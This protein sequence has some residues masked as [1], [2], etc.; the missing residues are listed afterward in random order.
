MRRSYLLGFLGCSLIFAVFTAAQSTVSGTAVSPNANEI[1][2]LKGR[3]D[4]LEL[5]LDPYPPKFKDDREK[6]QVE[7]D[8][9]STIRDLQNASAAAPQNVT[10][11]CMLGHTY[12]L[13]QNLDQVGDWEKSW[14]CY[15]RAIELVPKDP[16]PH[17]GLA[18]LL[19]NTP[20]FD[21]E[22]VDQFQAVIRLSDGHPRE[23][24]YRGLWF[25]SVAG[26][27]YQQ[28]V[29]WADAYL[30]LA[31]GDAY[32]IKARAATA[33]MAEKPSGQ[34]TPR[35]DS[36]EMLDKFLTFYYEDPTPDLAYSAISFMNHDGYPQK[37]EQMGPV[38]GF[39]AEFFAE[40]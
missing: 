5:H 6:E 9:A 3:I 40:S 37:E 28:A 10:L 30:R 11:L 27:H 12:R 7:R 36:E 20:G 14:E 39:F 25:A 34:A 26:G 38:V 31:P 4:N 33:V 19:A 18:V 23:D 22:S 29:Q 13:G 16:E 8:L 24:V 21:A 35:I 1:K 17:F 2:E 32:M 15:K